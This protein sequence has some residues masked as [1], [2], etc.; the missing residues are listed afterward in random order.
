MQV[1]NWQGSPET[2][3]YFAWGCFS[4]NFKLLSALGRLKGPYGREWRRP[5]VRLRK[6]HH[7][8][9]RL[10]HR[11]KSRMPKRTQ[12]A[13]SVR[14]HPHTKSTDGIGQHRMRTTWV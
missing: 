3:T 7:E 11:F 5:S 13:S 10:A 1:L 6:R 9:V 12:L 2:R 4:K 14:I 8:T